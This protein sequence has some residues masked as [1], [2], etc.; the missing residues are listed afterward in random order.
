MKRLWLACLAGLLSLGTT[1][2]AD[3][4]QYIPPPTSPFYRPALSPYLNLGLPGQGALNYYGLVRPQLAYNQAIGQLQSQQQLLSSELNAAVNSDPNSQLTTGHAA[5][6]FN[7]SHYYGNRG[8]AGSLA[9]TPP[10]ITGPG[11]I[12]GARTP[13]AGFGVTTV[14]ATNSPSATPS[15]R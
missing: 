8:G 9:R 1:P 11:I 3:A 7:Y 15:G 6:F 14:P 2:R 13:R 10:T 12:P 4:Q 5:R